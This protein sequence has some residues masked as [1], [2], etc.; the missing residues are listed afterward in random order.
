MKASLKPIIS[1]CVLVECVVQLT[2][3]SIELM[4][5]KL[6]QIPR[7]DVVSSE[8]VLN[9]VMITDDSHRQPGVLF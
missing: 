9:T 7:A 3:A 2:R 1:E 8:H 6:V 4:V 5:Y